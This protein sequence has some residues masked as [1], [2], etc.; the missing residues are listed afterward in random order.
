[1]RTHERT[2]LG[3]V[4]IWRHKE[5]ALILVGG[6]TGRRLCGSCK[7]LEI[8]LVRIAL[9]MHLGHDVLVVVVSANTRETFN[10]EGAYVGKANKGRHRERERGEERERINNYKIMR[11]LCVLS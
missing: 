11:A 1:M 8:K 2:E 6:I 7:A 5:I 9:A 4:M 10:V 3:A